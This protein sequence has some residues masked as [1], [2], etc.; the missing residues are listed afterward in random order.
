MEAVRQ[1]FRPEVVVIQ[2]GADS[3]AYDKLG[4]YNTTLRGHGRCVR[5]VK[6]WGLPLLVL[7]GGMLC[8]AGYRIYESF[9]KPLVFLALCLGMSLLLQLHA[10]PI[11]V[12][13]AANENADAAFSSDKGWLLF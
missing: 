7:G 5:F 6:E 13:V 10:I 12:T 1:R 2:C 3:L 8:F 4:T 9:R 11:R